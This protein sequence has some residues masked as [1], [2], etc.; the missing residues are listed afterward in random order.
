MENEINEP[1]KKERSKAVSKVRNVL[2]AE[3]PMTINA[4][5][6]LLPELTA[7]QISMSLCYLRKK[8][9]VERTQIPRI[10]KVGRKEVYAYTIKAA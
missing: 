3:T 6:Q 8:E 9:I 10:F 5:N 2:S 1:V 7:G 4:I